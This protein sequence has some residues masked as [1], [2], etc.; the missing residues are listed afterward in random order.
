M[1]I[2]FKNNNKLDNDEVSFIQAFRLLDNS[3]KNIFLSDLY[4]VL[5][6]HNSINDNQVKTKLVVI[7]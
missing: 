4:D 3:Y 5:I 1:L 7:K 6:N 2:S